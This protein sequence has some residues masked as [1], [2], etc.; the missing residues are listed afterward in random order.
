MQNTVITVSFTRFG[1][2]QTT[3]FLKSICGGANVKVVEENK[4]NYKRYR[5]SDKVKLSFTYSYYQESQ[6]R[7]FEKSLHVIFNPD[8][9]EFKV[10][11]VP[12][13]KDDWEKY[14]FLVKHHDWYYA[15]SD[16]HRVWSSGESNFKEIKA[17]RIKL[18]QS[19][20]VRAD[21]IWNQ[22]SK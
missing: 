4:I 21:N 10:S 13:F 18:G 6:A 17:L 9:I 14:E 20:C 3:D 19:D 2:T 11:N 7:Q 8:Y 22:Y 12:M 15:F 5:L 1:S 16:D